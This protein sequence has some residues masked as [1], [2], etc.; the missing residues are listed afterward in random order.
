MT[1]GRFWLIAATLTGT[2]VALSPGCGDDNEPCT[3]CPSIAGRYPLDFAD[4]T[5]PADCAALNVALPKGPLEIQHT[6]SELTAS[7][8]DVPLRGTLYQSLDFTLLGTQAQLDGGSTQLN[9]SG[10]YMPGAPDGGT[11]RL[12]G[13]FTG[14]YT[15]GSAQGAR[16]CTINRSYTAPQQGRP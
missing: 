8:E 3:S 9:L 12:S 4:D 13:T 2:A 6:D 15:R 16:R 14:T 7:L 5:V 1:S 11:G 10:R